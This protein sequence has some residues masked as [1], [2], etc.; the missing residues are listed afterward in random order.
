MTFPEHLVCTALLFISYRL[1]RGQQTRMVK[2]RA[3]EAS[4]LDYEKAATSMRLTVCPVKI[5]VTVS[6]QWLP[7]CAHFPRYWKTPCA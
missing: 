1:L 2:C 6:Q 7:L 3:S 4:H 5:E